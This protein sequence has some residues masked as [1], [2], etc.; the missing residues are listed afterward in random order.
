MAVMGI[1][2]Y[3]LLLFFAATLGGP[4]AFLGILG[5]AWFALWLDKTYGEA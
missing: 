2:F 4:F 3:C 1:V 5:V